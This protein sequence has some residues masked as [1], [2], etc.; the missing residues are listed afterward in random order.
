MAG[1]PDEEDEKLT[2][3][4][5]SLM[6]LHLQ[7]RN[8]LKSE[9]DQALYAD[10]IPTEFE[11]MEK[12]GVSRSTVRQA[13]KTLVD[14]G[15]LE[16]KQG[17]GT[18]IAVR[19]IEEWLGNLSSFIEIV[20]DMGMK[21]GIKLLERGFA[22]EPQEIA[23]TLGIEDQFYYIH[24]LRTANGVPLV[25]EKQYYPL[26]I[27]KAL[28]K[29]DLNNV[30]TYDILETQLGETLWEAKQQITCTAPTVEEKFFLGLDESTC[31]AILSERFVYN[32][33]GELIEYERN[34]YRADM[35][36]FNINL[37]RKRKI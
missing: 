31:C 8:L 3:D 34:V 13:V 25:Y 33:D 15:V 29:Y 32:Q 7:L 17:L 22:S 36:A 10:K 4:K 9:I 24:R 11:L 16:K 35:Y 23:D 1:N 19:P 2:L 6:P 37:T 18:F 28:D 21:P 14:E 5:Q 26:E 27:G 12:Y 20:N 30:S